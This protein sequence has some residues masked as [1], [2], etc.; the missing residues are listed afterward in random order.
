MVDSDKSTVS[1][2]INPVNDIPSATAQTLQVT[3]QVSKT[4]TLAG[5]D[6]DGDDLTFIISNSN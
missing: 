3:E 5:S 1:I 4:I 2:S 6:P